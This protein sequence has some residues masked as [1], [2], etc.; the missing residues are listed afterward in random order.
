MLRLLG[1]RS[2]PL[3]SIAIGA[4]LAVVGLVLGKVILVVAGAAAAVV[5]LV[6]V[7]GRRSGGAAGGRR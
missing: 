6:G 3:L 1:L 2:S 5:G 4:G 7:L